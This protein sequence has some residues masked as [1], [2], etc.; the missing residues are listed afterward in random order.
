MIKDA[1]RFYGRREE[2]PSIQPKPHPDQV[3][4]ERAVPGAV[5]YDTTMDVGT[6]QT[7]KTP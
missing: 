4:L 6:F 3:L 5:A 7:I 1:I 2:L